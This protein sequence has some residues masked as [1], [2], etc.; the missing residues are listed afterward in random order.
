MVAFVG[1]FQT[2][3]FFVSVLSDAEIYTIISR[4]MQISLDKAQDYLYQV[5]TS[6]QVV[7]LDFV[8]RCNL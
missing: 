7:P 1:Q 8:S 3:G 6:K 2:T 4:K 5:L